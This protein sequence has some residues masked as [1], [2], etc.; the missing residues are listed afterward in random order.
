LR[1]QGQLQ[2]FSRNTFTGTTIAFSTAPRIA[3]KVVSGH[4]HLAA[5]A[6]FSRGVFVALVCDEAGRFLRV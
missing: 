6:A 2:K 1:Y 3:S 4:L 5:I